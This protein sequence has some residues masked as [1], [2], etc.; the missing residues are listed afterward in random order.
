[1]IGRLIRE[2]R[3][4]WRRSVSNDDLDVEISKFILYRL[5]RYRKNI[6][7]SDYPEEFLFEVDNMI[8]FWEIEQDIFSNDYH[9]LSRTQ[10]YRKGFKSFIKNF[11]DLYE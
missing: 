3:E 11:H 1:M 6:K 9:N 4:A 5:R 7:K 2:I 8:K 10:A